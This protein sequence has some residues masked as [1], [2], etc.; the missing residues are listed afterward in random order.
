VQPLRAHVAG[1][2]QGVEQVRQ[3]A[4][5]DQPQVAVQPAQR[6]RAHPG[7]RMH[8]GETADELA[9]PP[10]L[11]EFVAPWAVA[12]SEL[13]VLRAAAYT[14]R[15]RIADRW[16]AGRV[17][18]LGD[19]AHLAPP[20]IG[21]GLGASLRDAHNL[22]WKLAAVLHGASDEEQLLDSYAAERAA[23]AV[24]VIRGTGRA[25]RRRR[26]R[27]HRDAADLAARRADDGGPA[28]P[29]PHRG[30]HP[31]ARHTPLSRTHPRRRC[32]PRSHGVC[33]QRFPNSTAY[34]VGPGPNAIAT[35]PRR[36][37]R[38]A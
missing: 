6:R 28:P 26:R 36:H 18:L 38:P 24:A 21:Q 19:A 30:A 9:T 16:R 4:E 10:R 5:V 20:F 23:H 22:A 32:V 14:F 31:P 15:A 35:E 11:A 7:G 8:P 33:R 34:S 2:R 3:P 13:D 17:L 12:P 27:P 29:R 37:G 1:E 25:A